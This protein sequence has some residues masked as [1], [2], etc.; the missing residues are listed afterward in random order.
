[1]NI[2]F[3][4]FYHFAFC[5][6]NKKARGAEALR[7]NFSYSDSVPSGGYVNRTYGSFRYQTRT[8]VRRQVRSGASAC[9]NGDKIIL[10]KIRCQPVFSFETP[11]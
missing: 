8:A 1:M 10:H 11:V 7:A 2:G 6:R 9:L 5:S 3:T 4:I